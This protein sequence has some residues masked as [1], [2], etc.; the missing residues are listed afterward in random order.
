M[1]R[2]LQEQGFTNIH[3]MPNCKKL[4]VL[5]PEELVY[6][7]QEPYKLC[8][9]SRVM[10][11]KGIEDAVRA[12]EAV[13]AHFGRTVYTLDIFGQIDPG[14]VQWFQDLQ[15]TFTADIRYGGLVPFDKSVEVLKDYF[16]L[17]FPT[18][19]Y[20]EGIPGTIIDAYAAGVPAIAVKWESCSDVLEDGATGYVYA[21]GSQS[22]LEGKLIYICQN[23][24]KWISMRRNCLEEAKK[25]TPEKVISIMI[26]RL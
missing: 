1:K 2:D 26:D 8:T 7:H 16:A 13:N 20:T 18:R 14:Q 11:E 23:S 5:S 10:Q 15:S 6:E 17:L 12:V 25:Y 3:V 19:F 21:F 4:T 9:F 24:E 22:E